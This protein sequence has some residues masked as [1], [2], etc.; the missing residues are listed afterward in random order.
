MRSSPAYAVSNLDLP[1]LT[2]ADRAGGVLVLLAVAFVLWACLRLETGTGAA[3]LAALAGL[4]AL[5][6]LGWDWGRARRV[7]GRRL[8]ARPDGSIWLRQ[9]GEGPYP[10]TVGGGTRLLGPSVFLDL[11]VAYP[12]G[13]RRLQAW[14]TP[15]DA[16]G[17]VRRQ[18]SVLLPRCGRAACT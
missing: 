7:P 14:I 5:A 11:Q 2:A 12:P 13:P 8:E 1:A 10:V 4:A 17:H 9:G 15:L 3:L 6:C 18:W 16:P